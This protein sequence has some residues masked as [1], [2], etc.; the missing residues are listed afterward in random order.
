MSFHVLLVLWISLPLPAQKS[1]SSCR[2]L[3]LPIKFKVLLH[4]RQDF[5]ER[6]KTYP[7]AVFLFGKQVYFF[8]GRAFFSF[9]TSNILQ[10]RLAASNPTSRFLQAARLVP[11]ALSDDPKL[12]AFPFTPTA[13]RSLLDAFIQERIAWSGEIHVNRKKLY[14]EVDKEMKQRL[15]EDW[16]VIQGCCATCPICKAKCCHADPQHFETHKTPHKCYRH[17]SSAFGGVHLHLQP[18]QPDWDICCNPKMKNSKWV[19]K[20][21]AL[22]EKRGTTLEYLQDR[23]SSWLQ[24]NEWAHDWFL[25]PSEV[26][27]QTKKYEM[28]WVHIKDVAHLLYKHY[29][30]DKCLQLEKKYNFGQTQVTEHRRVTQVTQRYDAQNVCSQNC[31]NTNRFESPICWSIRYLSHR[32]FRFL[33]SCSEKSHEQLLKNHKCSSAHL[34][35]STYSLVL[36]NVLRE[37]KKRW[38]TSKCLTLRQWPIFQLQEQRIE[39]I[40][41]APSH[42][43]SRKIR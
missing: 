14:D 18:D 42:R 20:D 2:D 27:E 16:K 22:N 5:I 6:M 30:H 43:K 33:D 7:A 37:P 38:R 31:W 25:S 41:V 9:Q 17:M 13:L 19:W 11:A 10:V 12:K 3:P 36:R 28:A 26:E 1:K 29:S 32:P 40:V 21:F 8:I 15:E 4:W 35:C 34:V 23:A 39:S 24:N